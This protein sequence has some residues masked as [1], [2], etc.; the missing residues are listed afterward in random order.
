M[1]SS[2]L[3]CVPRWSTQ[4]TPS[5]QTLG[6]AATKISQQ[7][8]KPLLPWQ[9]HVLDVALEIENGRFVYREVIVGVPR[10]QG[11]TTLILTLILLRALGAGGERI[12]YTAQT[13]NDARRKLVDDWLP[14]LDHTPF[15]QFYR[16]RLANGSEALRF[17]NGS[18]ASLVATTKKSGHGGTLDLAILDEAFAQADARMEQSLKPAMM[19]RPQ[20]QL[21]I[22]STAGTPS[23]SPYLLDKV[24]KGR[25]MVE[26]GLNHSVAYFEWAAA[27]DADPADPETWRSCMP[28]LG[29]TVTEDAVRSDFESMNLSE[30]RRAYLNL[31]TTT[32]VDPVIPMVVWDALADPNSSALDPVAIA[33]DIPPSRSSGVI[34]AAGKRADNKIHIEVVDQREGVEW[35]APT[36]AALVKA[37]R[38]CVVLCDKVGPAAALIPELERLGVTVETTEAQEMARACGLFYDAAMGDQ[39]RHLGGHDLRD[40]LDGAVKRPLND[41]WAWSRKN[42]QANASP[43]VAATLAHWGITTQGQMGVGV[44]DM[45][46]IVKSI[47]RK[48]AEAAAAA[49]GEQPADPLVTAPDPAQSP[50]PEPGKVVF[51]PF[52]QMPL[53]R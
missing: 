37:Q 32:S 41:A 45:E 4:R 17:R 19:T 27:E 36:I 9:Q 10:Q 51:I 52:S 13:R 12:V 15:S 50:Q 22:V 11:K 47:H 46:E 40:A 24:E 2:S 20:P 35:L 18:I 39:L 6:V 1:V 26:A 34:V 14:E 3:E 16:T 29:L 38:P 28:S 31:W 44:W 53:R 43:I 49:R 8:G 33:F 25:Q 5:R 42:S 7:L 30:F 23:E 21:W 48:D